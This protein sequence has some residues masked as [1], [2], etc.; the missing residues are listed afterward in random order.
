MSSFIQQ[1]L[2]CFI[3]L[4]SCAICSKSKVTKKDLLSAFLGSYCTL[5]MQT[6]KQI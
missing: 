3:F 6:N 4:R 2:E 5:I 1:I